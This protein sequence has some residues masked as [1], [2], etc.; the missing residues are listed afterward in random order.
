M[1]SL[2]EKQQSQARYATVA[3]FCRKAVERRLHSMKPAPSALA[4]TLPFNYLFVMS[5][6]A[7]SPRSTLC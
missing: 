7:A 1:V 4:I 5:A 3:L 6:T 2:S